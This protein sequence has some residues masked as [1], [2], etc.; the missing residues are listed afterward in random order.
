MT[1]VMFLPFGGLAIQIS[2][3]AVPMKLKRNAELEAD[4]L[5]LQYMYLAGYDPNEFLRFLDR[6]YAV[7]D[8]HL[9]RM[10]QVFSDFPSLNQRLRQDRA[11]VSTFPP[12]EEYVVDTSGFAEMK[13]KYDTPGPQLRRSHKHSTG[14]RLRRRAEIAGENE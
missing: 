2:D 7:E 13:A 10:A 12:R 8:R 1:P 4:L 5:G 14:P 9:S 11:M 6:G 3:I